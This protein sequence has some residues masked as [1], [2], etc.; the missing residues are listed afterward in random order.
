MGPAARIYV[1][2]EHHCQPLHLRPDHEAKRGR[3]WKASQK[4]PPFPRLTLDSH[5][6]ELEP[7]L[8]TRVTSG[9]LLNLNCSFTTN[10][11]AQ[12]TARTR[13]CMHL[14]QYWQ[15]VSTHKLVCI[16]LLGIAGWLPR[17]ARVGVGKRKARN[18]ALS[19]FHM[20]PRHTTEIGKRCLGE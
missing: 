16:V 10:W 19:S 4:P 5:R 14:A 9:S 12:S 15:E 3:G 17:S 11:G 13:G 18:K 7:I 8:L 20:S 1:L 6:P 2:R